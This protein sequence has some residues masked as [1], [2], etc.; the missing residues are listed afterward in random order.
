MSIYQLDGALLDTYTLDGAPDVPTPSTDD[1]TFN[2]YGLQN[3]SIRTRYVKESA[4]TMELTRRA[5]PRANGAY[6]ET[7]YWRETRIQ[8]RG[9]ITKPTQLTLEQEMDTLRK[10]LATFG[11]LLKLTF[12]GQPRYYE[13]YA[14]GLDQIYSE[15]DYYH[16]TFCP[17]QVELTALHPFGRSDNRDTFDSPYAI[18]SASTNYEIQ[19][20]GTAISDPIIYITIGTAGSCTQVTFTNT[21]TGEAFSIS[22]T[23]AD[24][25]FLAI[26]CEQKTVKKNSVTVDYTGILPTLVAGSNV[27][28][29]ALNGAGFS[30]SL[31]VQH[32]QRYY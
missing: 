15:R 22:D 32:Y 11:G 20:L 3:S 21:T 19:H 27:C 7:A 14:T 2:G 1:I 18:T 8:L 25:D 12:A 16:I 4:P 13:C 5:Y 28:N 29:I 30:A 9:T 23:F 26:D 10:N 24:G 31:S 6:P 17:Y